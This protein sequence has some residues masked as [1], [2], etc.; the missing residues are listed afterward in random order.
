MEANQISRLIEY[1]KP[2]DTPHT[3]ADTLAKLQQDFKNFYKQYDTRRGKSFEKTFSNEIVTW[4][5]QL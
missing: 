2:V 3:G 1:L 4:Y 5:E